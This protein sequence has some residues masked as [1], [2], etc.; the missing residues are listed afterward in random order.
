M[1]FTRIPVTRIG[2]DPHATT[3]FDHTV[4]TEAARLLATADVDVIAWNGTAGSWLGAAHDRE[5]VEAITAATGTPATT[6]TLAYLEAF[7]EFSTSRIGL[8]TPYTADVNQAITARYASEGIQVTGEHHLGL[9]DNESFARVD[10]TELIGP[11]RELATGNGQAPQALAYVCTNLYG[12]PVVAQVEETTGVPVLDS[13]A[14]TLWRC[15]AMIDA[16]PLEPRW[17]RLLANR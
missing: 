4:M 7:Q 16:A 11:S 14:V 9:T 3:Q 10:P 13:V 17:G 8:V 2:L 12:A 15:L 5:L 1:H 6:S